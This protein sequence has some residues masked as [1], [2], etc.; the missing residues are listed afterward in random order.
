MAGKTENSDGGSN[1]HENRQPSGHDA[2]S[3]SQPLVSVVIGPF[4][5]KLDSL[6]SF[7][8]QRAKSSRS[9]TNYGVWSS[10]A[11]AG[12]GT[13][14]PPSMVPEVST[15]QLGDPCSKFPGH[16]PLLS[17]RRLGHDPD[18]D[19]VGAHGLNS[20]DFGRLQQEGTPLRFL[21]EGTNFL[22]EQVEDAG[23]VVVIG[24]GHVH[25]CPRPFHRE[26]SD[27]THL[28]VPIVTTSPTPY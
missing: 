2:D 7:P 11:S 20:L 19:T 22:G 4:D 16:F 8:A 15:H 17:R 28:D 27:N 23:D 12:T 3:Y 24:K 6:E 1:T 14:T 13:G 26:I 5:M 10:N 9:V 18:G 21:T 25:D